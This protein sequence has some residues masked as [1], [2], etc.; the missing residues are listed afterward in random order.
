MLFLEEVEYIS[1]A[2]GVLLKSERNLLVLSVL[3]FEEAER[4][5]S[6]KGVCCLIS[7]S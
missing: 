5:F 1:G 2:P 3:I 7:P 6:L 4:I